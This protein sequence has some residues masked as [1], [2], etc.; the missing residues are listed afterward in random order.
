MIEE[1]EEKKLLY[2]LN[3]LTWGRVAVSYFLTAALIFNHFFVF[4][5]GALI[6]LLVAF[7]SYDRYALMTYDEDYTS[8]YSQG[9][10]STGKYNSP[11]ARGDK[12]LAK[13]LKAY[14]ASIKQ[15]DEYRNSE[16]HSRKENSADGRYAVRSRQPVWNRTDEVSR[17]FIYQEVRQ[18]LFN[19][20]INVMQNK[21]AK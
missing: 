15:N 13:E 19:I 8:E 17:S 10:A 20:E 7:F 18:R 4:I 1:K 6:V 9:F 11:L 2:Y 16:R 5:L 12:Y 14:Y 21:K 3:P